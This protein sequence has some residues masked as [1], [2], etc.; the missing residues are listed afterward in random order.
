MSFMY[1]YICSY[2]A[3][4]CEHCRVQQIQEVSLHCQVCHVHHLSKYQSIGRRSI[5]MTQVKDA[6]TSS[7]DRLILSRSVSRV[8]GG[9]HSHKAI[10]SF[11]FLMA[12][13]DRGALHGSQ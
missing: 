4:T 2:K 3:A 10:V 13:V 8:G 9:V 1:W 7:I 11:F 12:I 6:G 5:G